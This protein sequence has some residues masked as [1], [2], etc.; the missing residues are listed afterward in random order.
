MMKK[1]FTSIDQ[2]ISTF[3]EDVQAILEK[4]RVTIQKAAPDAK[5]AISYQIPTFKL[6]GNLVHFAAWESHVG[7]YPGSGAIKT[8]KKELASYKQAKGTVQFPLDEPIP[9]D[10]IAKIVRLRVKE[11]LAKKK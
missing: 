7:F 3:P 11:N 9:L 4:V 1:G 10:L 8:F 5:E 2:Y 6:H